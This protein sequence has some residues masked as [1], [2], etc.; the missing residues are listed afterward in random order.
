MS[1]NTSAPAPRISRTIARERLEIPTTWTWSESDLV[2]LDFLRDAKDRG[3]RVILDGVFNHVG[4]DHPAFLDVKERG[5]ES[6]VRGLVQH[7]VV[8]SVRVRRLGGI[9]RTA[10][11]SKEP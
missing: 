8:G 5:V 2:F 6:P 3:F 11:L 1:T 4:V 7:P 10:R 9:R